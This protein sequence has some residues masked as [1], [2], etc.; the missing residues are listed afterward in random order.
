MASKQEI[1]NVIDSTDIVALVSE[2]VKLEKQGKNFKGL[3]PFHSED[4]PSFVVSPDKKLAH[5]FGCSGGGDPIKFLMQI[6]NI[7]FG[8]ALT[9]LAKKNGIKISNIEQKTR[10]NPLTKY[11][12][13]MQIAQA[14]YKKNLENT[15]QGVEA[16][17]YMYKRGLNDET[18]KMFGIGLSPQSMDSLYQVLKESGFLELDISDVGLI[19]KSDRGY[20]DLFTRRIMF[21]IYN[22][23]GQPIGFSGRIFNSP[24][25][26]QPKY[27]NSRETILFKKKDT[28]FNLHQAKGEILKK[29][30]VILH[31]GQMDVIASYRSGL[32]EA[33]CTMG[34]ALSSN[35][36]MT[37][38]KYSDQA[39]ICYD[40]DKAGIQASLKAIRTFQSAGFKVHLVLLPDGM[41]PDEYVLKFGTEAYV[42]YFESHLLD[43]NAYI[44]EQAIANKDFS[45]GVV[46][47]GVKLQVFE[48]LFSSGSN[49]TASSYLK[50]LSSVLKTSY[51]SVSED[52]QQYC[53]RNKPKESVEFYPSNENNYEDAQPK[54]INNDLWLSKYEIR[55]FMY[56]KSSREKAVYID[57]LLN[58]RIDA[59][60]QENLNLWIS[61][62]NRYYE[63]YLEFNEKAFVRMLNEK[64]LAYY[65]RMCEVLK[66]DKTPYTDEDLNA[67][68]NKLD[69]VK[70]DKK[71]QKIDLEIAKQ[72]DIENQIKLISKKFE[73]NKQKEQLKKLRRK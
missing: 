65:E 40:G 63:E 18:I 44:F 70:Y 11:Y 16:L 32:K 29:K 71:N 49:T 3:C 5:C 27:V 20:Y 59:I 43:S 31:E 62:V 41:D 2:Y 53:N 52:Y 36:A 39:I 13:I 33:I 58:D 4:T 30:R 48:M 14:F 54:E 34:T 23:S 35:Q 37:L 8:E 1:Q 69:F 15:D 66:K 21:P 28:L 50:K 25:K 57:K 64:D 45:D 24:D 67:C 42:E 38:R 22:E 51:E 9:R 19:D 7:D 26:N 72:K 60:S 47:E 56:A 17:N 55:L 6:E 73:N 61:M 68:L 12:Q 46:T 10:S